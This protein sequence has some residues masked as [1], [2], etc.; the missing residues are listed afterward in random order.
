[1]QSQEAMEFAASGRQ[2]LPSRRGHGEGPGLRPGQG[3]GPRRLRAKSLTLPDKHDT[4]DDAGGDQPRHRWLHE[5]GAGRGKPPTNRAL[6][7]GSGTVC[8]RRRPEHRRLFRGNG[9]GG[10]NRHRRTDAGVMTPKGSE[11]L[12]ERCSEHRG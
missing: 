1:V 3:V 5:S 2:P 4:A 7:D 10:D 8:W 6:I 11:A 12:L 9:A